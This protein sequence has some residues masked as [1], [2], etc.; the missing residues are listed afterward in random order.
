M[1]FFYKDDKNIYKN[2]LKLIKVAGAKILCRYCQEKCF[3]FFQVLYAKC[4]YSLKFCCQRKVF[5]T[6]MEN[7]VAYERNDSLSADCPTCCADII[8]NLLPPASV[9]AGFVCKSS[10]IIISELLHPSLT[11]R[12]W[13]FLADFIGKKRR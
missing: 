3:P 12:G 7:R 2:P 11:L 4:C 10:Q 9:Q 1:A 5:K 13:S 6:G 8:Q